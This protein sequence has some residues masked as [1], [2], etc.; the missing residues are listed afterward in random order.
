[1]NRLAPNIPNKI[2][3]PAQCCIYCGKS[4]TKITSLNKH[5]V[6]CDLLQK[7]KKRSSSSSLRIEDEEPLPSQR[8]MFD[9]LIENSFV[10]S[11]MRMSS[12]VMIHEP[13]SRSSV[14]PTT[15]WPMVKTNVV[16]GP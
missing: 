7:G 3:Q 16:C 4:Y 13:I 8:K 15:P 2:K 14:K 12:L 10:S 11:G 9:M 6:I 5:T 1:M